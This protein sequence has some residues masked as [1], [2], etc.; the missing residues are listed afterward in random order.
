MHI[1]NT[2]IADEDLSKKMDEIFKIAFDEDKAILEAI[3]IEENKGSD[4]PALRLAIDK[5]ANVY[6]KRIHRLIE[7]ENLK[8]GQ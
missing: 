7:H 8:T 3:Q 1:R 6:R 4:L 2:A 5:G